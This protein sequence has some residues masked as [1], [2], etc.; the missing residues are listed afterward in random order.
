MNKF[1]ILISKKKRGEKDKNFRVRIAKA[2]DE[3]L[4]DAVLV[5]ERKTENGSIVTVLYCIQKNESNIVSSLKERDGFQA[6]RD[7]RILAAK[8]EIVV[9][10]RVWGPAMKIKK[11]LEKNGKH[12]WMR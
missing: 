11:Y 12:P 2:L 10:L 1:H 7:A 6:I 3:Q 8:K 5:Q 4:I 9:S